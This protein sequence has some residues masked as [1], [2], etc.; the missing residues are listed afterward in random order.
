MDEKMRV[1]QKCGRHEDDIHILSNG[2]CERCDDVLFGYHT[3]PGL[4]MP[5]W[6][7]PASPEIIFDKPEV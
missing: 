1:C 5:G 3:P 6:P 2:Y 4:S 7:Q